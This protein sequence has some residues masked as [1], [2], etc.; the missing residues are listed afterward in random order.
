MWP[1]PTYVSSLLISCVLPNIACMIQVTMKRQ[2]SQKLVVKYNG[3]VLLNKRY[4]FARP[5]HGYCF[6]DW[7]SEGVKLE[8]CYQKVGWFDAVRPTIAGGGGR[9]VVS[10]WSAVNSSIYRR[11][12]ESTLALLRLIYPLGFDPTIK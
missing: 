4:M 3:R 5:A 9:T 10:R 7:A 12:S 8:I 11:L 1:P 2:L 6:V